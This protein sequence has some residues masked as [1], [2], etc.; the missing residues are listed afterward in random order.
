MRFLHLA[1]IHLGAVPEK[2]RHYSEK[3]ADE[4][5]TTF[6]EIIRDEGAKADLVLI[7]GDVFH[8][9]PLKRELKELNALL[10]S[11]APTKVVLMAGNHDYMGKGSNYRGFKWADNIGFFDEE[12]PSCLYMEDI[13][14]YVYG[15]SYEHR[16]IKE[17]LY[18]HL[19]P[20]KTEG[21]HILMA[22]GGDEKHIPMDIRRLSMAGFDYIALGHIHQ[23]KRL[24][25]RAVYAG[26]PEPI[27]RTDLGP[28]GYIRG[29]IDAQG[30]RLSFIEACKREYKI[31]DINVDT[32]TSQ[33]T[34]EQEIS[35]GIQE[36]G[37]Q[38]MYR[39]R[40]TGYRDADISF[41][42]EAMMALGNISDITDE[43]MPWFDTERLYVENRDNL[44][45]MFIRKIDSMP[46]DE[47][48]KRK[49]LSTGLTAMYK[50]GGGTK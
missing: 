38:H 7:A 31:L 33:F 1:D 8:R 30:L 35:Q 20:G 4:I 12:K 6:T 28:R 17:G 39:I 16:E 45:G 15:L 48:Y 43:T 25:D 21:Y 22:H 18:D 5:K 10:A 27:D 50:S 2:G 40:L 36:S 41:D 44:I 32:E 34:L 9:A 3:R 29:E 11:I 23:P 46:V 24:N 37:V 42:T 47:A 26:S 19:R 13:H 14:T 49:L